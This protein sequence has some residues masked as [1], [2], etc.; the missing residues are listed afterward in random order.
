MTAG[1]IQELVDIVGEKNV[2]TG[3]SSLA[4]ESDGL[5]LVRGQGSAIVLPADTNETVAVM[6]VL[7]REGVPVVPRGA[8]TGLTGGASPTHGGVTIGTARMRKIISID[9]LERTALVQAGVVNADLSLASK[10]HGLFYA[11]DP[12]SQAACTLG[13][14]VANNSGG[15]HCFLHGSTTRHVRGLKLV[16]P[17]GEILDLLAGPADPAGFDLIGLITGSEGMFGVLTEVCLNLE[18]L[19]EEIQTIIA[20]FPSLDAACDCVSEA[21]AAH[22]HASAIEILDKLTIAAVEDSIFAAGYPRDAE[23][24]LLVEAEGG[25]L[26]V[27][28]TID[29]ILELSNKHGALETR[30]ARDVDERARLW[31]GRKGAFGAMGRVAP[32]LY[33]ADV[34]APRTR[35]REIVSLAVKIAE[36]RNLRLGNVFHAGDGNLHPNIAYD[37]RDKDEVRR[38]LEAGQLIMKACIERGGSLTGEHGVGIEKLGH[39]CDIFGDDD[40]AVMHRVRD[41]IDP[42]RRMNPGKVLPLR[43]CREMRG[44]GLPLSPDIEGTPIGGAHP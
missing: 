10:P 44:A 39:M 23:A 3:S 27:Q 24:V 18:P 4:W 1:W 11:P 30:R 9:P 31:A 40:L 32:D 34:V 36:E 38:V 21:I 41:A 19:P 5:S 35:L 25:A 20:V 28:R 29:L 37:R 42:K 14:N 17:E 2:I 7:A 13:G 43:A 6:K 33:V 8:G 12:S 26:E 16:D 15:P 22:M